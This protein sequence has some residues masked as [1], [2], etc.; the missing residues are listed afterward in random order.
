VAAATTAL[1]A[2]ADPRER[3]EAHAILADTWLPG[4]ESTETP[5]PRRTQIAVRRAETIEGMYAQ[6]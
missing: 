1:N 6:S 5:K 3:I 2:E 4:V